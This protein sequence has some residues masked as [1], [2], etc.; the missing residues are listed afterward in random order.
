MHG[1]GNPR[2]NRVGNIRWGTSLDNHDDQARH[3]TRARGSRSYQA[4]LTEADIPKIDRFMANGTSYQ[5][6]AE[7]FGV[8]RTAVYYA[9]KRITWRHVP[10]ESEAA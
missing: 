7:H 6:C 2:N 9:H 1:D 8:E 5:K 10:R 3:G 4:K